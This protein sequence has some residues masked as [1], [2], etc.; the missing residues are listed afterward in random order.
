MSD[1]NLSGKPRRR[2]RKPDSSDDAARGSAKCAGCEDRFES[3]PYGWTRDEYFGLKRAQPRAPSAQPQK[4]THV[5]RLMRLLDSPDGDAA[6]DAL[7]VLNRIRV[8]F[9]W[10][11]LAPAEMAGAQRVRFVQLLRL[12][13]GT[14]SVGEARNA[15]RSA[16]RMLEQNNWKWRWDAA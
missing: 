14:N 15:Y 2:T 6:I 7:G 12:M 3:R 16:L 9:D 1:E 13:S 10:E 4:P 5:P 11:T 8:S